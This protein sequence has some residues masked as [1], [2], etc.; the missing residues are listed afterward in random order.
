MLAA[1]RFL[2][3]KRIRKGEDRGDTDRGFFGDC[4]SAIVKI[5]LSN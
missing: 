3:M 1:V 5:W 2:E 4:Q